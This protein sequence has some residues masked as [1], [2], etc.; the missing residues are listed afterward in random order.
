MRIDWHRV[1]AA[2]LRNGRF[3]LTVVCYVITSLIS[4]GIIKPGSISLQYAQVFLDVMGL[5]GIAASAMYQPPRKSLNEMT[6]EERER[7]FQEHPEVRARWL[8]AHPTETIATNP[9]TEKK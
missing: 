6:P 2:I 7:I 9:N 3:W 4:H 1:D 5:F 8:A